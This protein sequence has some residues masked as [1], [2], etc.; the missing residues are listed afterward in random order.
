MANKRIPTT[1]DVALLLQ[2]RDADQ[3]TLAPEFQRNAIWPRPAKAY[4]IDTILYDRPIPLLFFART[5]NAQTGRPEYEVIDGQQRL[6]AVFQFLDNKFRL[7][8]SPLD[9][10]WL[11]QRWSD[12]SKEHKERILNYDFTVAELTG[13]ADT[14]IR[15]MFRRMNRYVVP[16]NAQEQRHAVAEGIFKNFVEEV[17]AWPFWIEARIFTANAANRRRTDEFAA[18]VAI[19]LIEG[20]QDK[21]KSVDLYYA[22]YEYEFDAV[23]DIRTRLNDYTEFTGEVLPDLRTMQLRRPANF[24]ALIGALDSVTDQGSSLES[25]DR[26]VLRANLEKF[27]R[28]I[29]S[30]EPSVTGARYLRAAS[31]QTDNLAPRQIR[32]EILADVISKAS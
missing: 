11:N 26:Q 19:L 28:D 12:L 6:R 9:A 20:P 31:R 2:L 25:L 30:Q 17:G 8:E 16:L 3:L 1:K 29:Q 21:K 32:I 5:I 24:Y 13:Y 10:P 15:D 4:L 7:T 23:D 14:D 22:A 27:D 18:E